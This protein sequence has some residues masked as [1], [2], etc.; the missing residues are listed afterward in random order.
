[1]RRKKDKSVGCGF[2]KRQ[3]TSFLF[4][5]YPENSHQQGCCVG[6]EQDN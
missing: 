1:M 4:S 3:L 6:M 2:N 5:H